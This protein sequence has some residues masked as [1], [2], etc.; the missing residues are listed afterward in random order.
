MCPASRYQKLYS[1]YQQ[2][3]FIYLES[4]PARIIDIH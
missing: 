4:Y 2:A 1:K 3:L